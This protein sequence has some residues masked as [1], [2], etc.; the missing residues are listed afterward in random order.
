M[1][2]VGKLFLVVLMLM[3]MNAVM[4]TV[5]AD[6]FKL[7]YSSE[8]RKN[9]FL[10]NYGCNSEFDKWL[11]RGIENIQV[12]DQVGYHENQVEKSF[13]RLTERVMPSGLAPVDNSSFSLSL[14]STHSSFLE[15]KKALQRCLKEK[16]KKNVE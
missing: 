6:G 12:G 9:L 7:T 1:K 2:I 8:E 14:H 4:S 16:I 13:G 5:D 11:T 15:P 3:N 10:A